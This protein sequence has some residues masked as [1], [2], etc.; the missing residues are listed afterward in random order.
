MLNGSLLLAG[1]H[2]QAFLGV[3]C[4][5]SLFCLSKENSSVTMNL[6]SIERQ[7]LLFADRAG[8]RGL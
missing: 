8:K 2:R 3:L 1:Y 4:T 5:I 7:P 6:I